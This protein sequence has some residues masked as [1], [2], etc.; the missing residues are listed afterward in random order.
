MVNSRY[1]SKYFKDSTKFPSKRWHLAYVRI[2]SGS[3][4]DYPWVKAAKQSL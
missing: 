4:S 1:L 2:I 3:V